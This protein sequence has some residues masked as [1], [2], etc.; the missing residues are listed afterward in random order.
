MY[1]ELGISEKLKIYLMRVEEEIKEEFKKIENIST[2]NSL[3]V[4]KAF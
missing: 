2:Y 3:K 4:L 1:N